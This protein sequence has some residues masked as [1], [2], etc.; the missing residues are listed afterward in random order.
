MFGHN[1]VPT[2][3]IA[4]AERIVAGA[5]S[6]ASCPDYILRQTGGAFL[7][8]ARAGDLVVRT[9][10][11]GTQ[12]SA[13][14]MVVL[15]DTDLLLDE[16]LGFNSNIYNIIRAA[17]AD[18]RSPEGVEWVLR[19]FRCRTGGLVRRVGIWFSDGTRV[20]LYH[21]TKQLYERLG[22]SNPGGVSGFWLDNQ[23]I[24]IEHGK[25][26][27]VRNYTD[28]TL[29]MVIYGVNKTVDVSQQ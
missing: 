13:Y 21:D 11:D 27:I 4:P 15:S 25:L 10:T 17:S 3:P 20:S 18:V 6:N 24:L 23:D 29:E 2:D 28:E 16:N 19:S 14:V 22:L 26:M 8:V 7:T 1:V 9:A 5:T 12:S